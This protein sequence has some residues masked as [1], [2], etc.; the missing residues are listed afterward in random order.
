MT[1]ELTIDETITALKRWAV[2][3]KRDGLVAPQSTPQ[4]AELLEH[5]ATLLER[6]A[7]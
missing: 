7:K 6:R 1:K 5:A 4:L 2:G 3:I